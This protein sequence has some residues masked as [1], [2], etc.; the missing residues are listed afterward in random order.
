[1]KKIISG[2]LI[3][4]MVCLALAGCGQSENTPVTAAEDSLE[5]LFTTVDLMDATIADL[6]TEMEAGNVTS[7]QLTQMYID[8]I[9]AYDKQLE[10]NSVIAINP[11][12][13][14]DARALDQERT[15]GSVRGPLHGIPVLVK[16]N[17]DVKGMATSAGSIILSDM[18]APEDAFVV[19]QLRDAGAVILGQTNMSEFAYAAETSRST[20]GGIT[21]NPY[22]TLRTPGGSSGGSAVAVTCNFAAAALGTDTGGSIRVP[23]SFNNIYG[24]RP[25]KGLTSIN[26]VVPLKAYKDTVGTMA[27]TA[28]DM[29]LLLE[30]IAGTDEGDDY[31]VEADANAL[32]GSGY[33]GSLSEDSLKGIRIGYLGNSF[34]FSMMTETEYIY[35]QPAL[36]VQPMFKE[37]LANLTKAGAELVC[38][39]EVFTSDIIDELA[40]GMETITFEYDLNKYLNDKGDAAKYK[41]LK[42]LQDA[43][44]GGIGHMYLNWAAISYFEPAAT[45]EE[46]ENPYSK[47]V[48]SFQRLPGWKKSLK[49]REEI[50]KLLKENDIDAVAYLYASDIPVAES[51]MAT[52]KV[53]NSDYL[54]TFSCKHGLPD[55]TL[56]MGFSEIDEDHD[57]EMPLGI[58]VFADF[59]NEETLMKIAYAYEKQAGDIIRRE[60]ENTPALKDEAL[61]AFLED[62]IDKAYVI[63]SSKY[64]EAV[65]GKV[66]LMLNAADK[67]MNV[68]KKDPYAVYDAARELAEAY[69]KVMTVT[70]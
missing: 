30:V 45:F 47:T 28:E 20:L 8:R 12:A 70:G 64:K 62:L 41:T 49:G 1:M 29:A 11:E 15:E 35:Q 22:D 59:G 65:A 5:A 60:P 23:S 32:L 48:G 21:H 42:D 34:S 6:Q 7:E 33:T 18:I 43:N 51:E 63:G 36:N 69:D 14:D 3:T 58:N 52:L 68:D 38:L 24:I 57:V 31:T 13:L 55:V 40:K 66:Q 16:A 4:L 56:P 50:S 54:T 61:N 53:I 19:K 27:R 39:E 25:S 17:T 46:T 26:G 37:V 10:L 67:A 44:T 2:L 9:E